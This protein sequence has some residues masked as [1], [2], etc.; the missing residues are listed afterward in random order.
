MIKKPHSFIFLRVATAEGEILLKYQKI[1]Y[2][3]VVFKMTETVAINRNIM[4]LFVAIRDG[5][6]LLQGQLTN[7][8]V[9]EI[10]QIY[11]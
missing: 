2:L 11:P 4:L 9:S 10:L 5:L 7:H 6:P 3:N 8:D 1:Q